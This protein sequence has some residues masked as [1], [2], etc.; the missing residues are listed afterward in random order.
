MSLSSSRGRTSMDDA[1][2]GDL[3]QKSMVPDNFAVRGSPWVR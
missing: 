3:N 2:Q 1:G